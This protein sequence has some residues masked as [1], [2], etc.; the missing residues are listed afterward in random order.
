MFFTCYTLYKTHII[1]TAKLTHY[2]S[3][4]IYIIYIYIFY[5]VTPPLGWYHR[6][7]PTL[8]S[9]MRFQSYPNFHPPTASVKLFY[10]SQSHSFRIHQRD[11]HVISIFTSS[12]IKIKIFSSTFNSC[13]VSLIFIVVQ[14]VEALRPG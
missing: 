11:F 9:L 10:R 13:T 12:K 8:K 2:G 1:M 14:S 3:Q 7:F 6:V 4:I 5:G